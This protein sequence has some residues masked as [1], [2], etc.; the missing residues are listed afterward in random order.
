MVDE[1]QQPGEV[2]VRES[3]ITVGRALAVSQPASATEIATR[4]RKDPSNTKKVVDALVEAGA[5]TVVE[6]PA[7]SGERTGRPPERLY[8]FAPGERERFL[9]LFGGPDPMQLSAGQHLVFVEVGSLADDVLEI[10]S[11]PELVARAAWSALCDGRRQELIIGFDGD[12]AVEG[13]MDLMAA[14]SA[15]K[16]AA[17]RAAVSKVDTTTELVRWAH[18]ARAARPGGRSS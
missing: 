7:P 18:N 16:V 12:Q 15:A 13:S 2:W 17:T 10:L 6:P 8:D 3:R 9:H 14:L 11:R 4:A 1:R 5:L